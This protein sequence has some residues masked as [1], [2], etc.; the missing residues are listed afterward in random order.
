MGQKKRIVIFAIILSMSFCYIMSGV[1]SEAQTKKVIISWADM[2]P[3]NG[4][5]PEYLKKAAEAVKQA[6]E[7][8]VEFRF[9]WSNSLLAVKDVP[10]GIK[11][12]F[13]DSGWTA[14]TYTPAEIP[15]MAAFTTFLYHPKGH[16]AVWITEKAYE[17][18]DK[19]AEL[20]NEMEKAMDAK[21]WFVFAYPAYPMFSKK[22]V[23][24]LDDMKGMILRVS[25][26]NFGKMVEAI[27]ARS[28]T[29]AASE[30]YSSLDKGIVDGAVVGVEWG[31]RYGFYEITKFLNN[32]NVTFQAC[33]GP[34]SNR[35]LNMM[36]DADRKK[37]MEI[38][39]E[40][41]LKY[42]QALNDSDATYRKLYKEKGMEEVDFP[43]T[44]RER[45]AKLPAVQSIPKQWVNRTGPAARKVMDLWF[46]VSGTNPIPLD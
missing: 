42:A 6:T 11:S 26:E 13:A 38:G 22:K 10:Q 30:T 28:E 19:S 31:H 20:Q 5:R 41:S 8:R 24:S 45:W 4:L 43:E 27:G 37:F 39:R 23:T 7:G 17:M 35:K 33:T 36:T 15:L 1:E 14:A 25:G 34:V 18:Y 46:E 21:V 16:D 9:H 2:G 32:L 44:E 40:Y 3:E 29:I 12:G